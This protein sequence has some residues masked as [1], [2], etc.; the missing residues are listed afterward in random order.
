MHVFY[1]GIC[2]VSP[3]IWIFIKLPEVDSDNSFFNCKVVFV[4]AVKVF[5]RVDGAHRSCQV[6]GGCAINRAWVFF[7]VLQGSLNTLTVKI[8]RRWRFLRKWFHAASRKAGK[9]LFA[10]TVCRAWRVPLQK[11]RQRWLFFFFFNKHTCDTLTVT[12]SG[13]WWVTDS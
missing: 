2:K 6:H 7:L 1:V 9:F 8:S 10:Y 5:W 13:Q 4:I 3:Y 11:S 12:Q